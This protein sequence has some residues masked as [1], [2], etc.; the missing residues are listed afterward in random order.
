M[1]I[2]KLRTELTD[3]PLT[4]GYS[5]FTDAAAAADLNTV[6]RT[7]N[8]TSMT[9]SEILN[10]VDAT[11]WA[12]LDAAE[13]QTVW[14]IVHLGTINPFGVEATLMIGVFEGGSA[15]I[16]A[17]QAARKDDVSRAVELNIGWVRPGNIQEARL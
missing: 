9:G 11:E 14:D 3:D 8:K 6:Y 12:A 4:R 16:T 2:D 5:G 15:T 1:D 10:N 7:K 17:L 13:K